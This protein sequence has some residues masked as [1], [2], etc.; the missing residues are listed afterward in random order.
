MKGNVLTGWLEEKFWDDGKCWG[1]ESCH[2]TFLQ[3]VNGLFSF[4][5][6]LISL[7]LWGSTIIKKEKERII[8]YEPQ[9]ERLIKEIMKRDDSWFKKENEQILSPSLGLFLFSFLW[10][11]KERICFS[12][13]FN[14]ESII[15][16]LISFLFLFLKMKKKTF[17]SELTSS[18]FSFLIKRKE[19][20]I[21]VNDVHFL[22]LESSFIGCKE[23][24]RK[25][26]NS[27]WIMKIQVKKENERF[28]IFNPFLFPVDDQSLIGAEAHRQRKEEIG[29]S[30]ISLLSIWCSFFLCGQALRA[31][32][33]SCD[34]NKEKK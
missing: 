1:T 3:P 31:Q 2:Q 9:R 15:Y 24:K 12:I 27:Q 20:K 28:L 29:R 34:H 26:E 11:P 32:R 21:P 8:V 33:T 7:F 14:Q 6:K 13:F 22:S 5:W 18:F 17:F 10:S 16:R 30:G 19:G 25:K 4:L 23:R